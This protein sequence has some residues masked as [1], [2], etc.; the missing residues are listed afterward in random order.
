MI[1]VNDFVTLSGT[2]ATTATGTFTVN[3]EEAYIDGQWRHFNPVKTMNI[4]TVDYDTSLTAQEL[5]LVRL[6]ALNNKASTT[7]TPDQQV[8]AASIVAKLGSTDV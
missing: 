4:A 5:A 6:L 2:V 8:I 3:I 1:S 7:L